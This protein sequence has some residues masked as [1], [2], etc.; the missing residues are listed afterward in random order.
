MELDRIGELVEAQPLRLGVGPADAGRAGPVLR[1]VGRVEGLDAGERVGDL[2][3]VTG[4]HMPTSSLERGW[5]FV[6][7]GT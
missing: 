6:R 5:G 3:I 7:W 1:E 4:H 2:A